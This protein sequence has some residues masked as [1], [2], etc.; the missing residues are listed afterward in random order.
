MGDLADMT[1]RRP[2]YIICFVIYIAACIG[3]ALQDNYAALLVIRCIQSSGSSATIALAYGVVADITTSSERGTYMSLVSMGAMA[4]PAL[5]PILGGLLSQFLGWRSIFWFLTIIAGVYLVVS[6]IAYPETA[7]NVVG[8]GSIP[9]PAWDQSLLSWWT[10]RKRRPTD[11]LQRSVSQQTTKEARAKLSK[12]RS[13]RLPNPIKAISVIFE[14]DSG[15]L[16]LYAS[17]VYTAF[18]CVI[19][20][21]PQLFA[22][23][24]HYDDLQ[25]G[26]AFI[27]FGVGCIC[28]SLSNGRMLDWN[29]RRIAKLVGIKVDKKRGE[30]LR[31]FPIEKAR[32][33]V[34]FPL[35]YAGNIII[36]IYGWLLAVETHVAGPLTLLFF[37]GFFLNGAFNAMSTMLIDL[38]PTKPATATAANNLIR[39]WMG[40]GGTAVIIP[41]INGLGRGWAFTLI[42]LLLFASSF[43]PWLLLKWGPKWREERRLREERHQKEKEE[44][45]KHRQSDGT[46]FDEPKDEAAVHKHSAHDTSAAEAPDEKTVEAG[47]SHAR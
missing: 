29:Y 26:L 16:L 12:R 45:E 27:P 1:G 36:I 20:S 38:Y 4:G 42:G 7:R 2:V 14:K 32:L 23:I 25:I 13:L 24:Y 39:C 19:S 17:W 21:L 6:V 35:L 40:A 31:N 41:I 28:T 5:G 30:D 15:I 33:Q 34:A 44:K 18:Y 43:M 46:L 9:P 10:T 8:D 47:Q 3:I 22:Q 37:V 11:Q